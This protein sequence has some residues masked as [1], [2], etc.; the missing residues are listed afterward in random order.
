MHERFSERIVRFDISEDMM[1]MKYH[2][3]FDKVIIQTNGTDIA[4]SCGN[5]T[6][7]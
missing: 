3:K 4:G 2:I 5:L 1:T 7:E 6:H